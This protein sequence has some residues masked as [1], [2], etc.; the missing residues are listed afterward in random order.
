M[1]LDKAHGLL[2]GKGQPAAA[3]NA[4]LA[5]A[6]RLAAAAA[7]SGAGDLLLE[8]PAA[9]ERRLGEEGE[10][11]AME[12][13]G[14][15]GDEEPILLSIAAVGVGPWRRLR[16]LR[17]GCL[18][19][20]HWALPRRLIARIPP[21]QIADVALERLATIDTAAVRSARVVWAA[22]CVPRAAAKRS[23]C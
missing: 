10:D 5:L 12:E 3:L 19:A 4:A 2:R 18:V 8:S 20:E 17:R 23:L 9:L 6:G 14:E 16:A 7:A 11:A 21:P 22:S 1:M 15:E 13:A